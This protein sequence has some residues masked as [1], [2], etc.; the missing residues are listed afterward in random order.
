MKNSRLNRLFNPDSNRCFDIA[1]DHGLFNERA[2]LGGIENIERAIQVLSLAGPDGIQLSIGQAAMLQTI[3]G[4]SK[5]A[6]ILRLDVTNV[7]SSMV[8]EM[9]YS[10]MVAEPIE[11]ALRLDAACV[12][13]TLFSI[14]GQPAITDQCISNI[15]AIKPACDRFAM[16]L[17]VETLVFQSNEKGPGFVVD[18]DTDR[19]LALVRQATELGADIVKADPTADATAYR[20][21]VEAARVP[22]VVRASGRASDR[23]ILERTEQMI[24]QG[25]AGIFF[26]RNIL[27]HPD[28]GGLAR[29]LMAI[30]HDRTKAAEAARFI[31][32]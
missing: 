19:I 13:L 23:D 18:G 30:V 6:L 7:Y 12:V 5:P 1:L 28:P 11:Q 25:S 8:Q 4:K 27:Q 24:A 9:Y 2:F 22:V 20:K 32:S 10:R 26:G 15:L 31:R 16:P 14:P 21:V 29:A 17:M 3:P